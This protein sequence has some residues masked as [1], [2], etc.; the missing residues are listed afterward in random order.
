MT[1]SR[2]LE[3]IICSAKNKSP[4]RNCSHGK[5]LQIHGVEDG[6]ELTEEEKQEQIP[7]GQSLIHNRVGWASTYLKK[8]GLLV[9]ADSTHKCN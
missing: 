1:I 2:P 7:S 8:A 9:S 6:L 3:S 5:E 4:A